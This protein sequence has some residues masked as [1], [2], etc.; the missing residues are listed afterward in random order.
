MKELVATLFAAVL[1]V[2]SAFAQTPA[3]AQKPAAASPAQAAPKAAEKKELTEQQKRMGDCSKQ[4]SDKGMKGDDRNTFMSAC[5][6]GGGDK[7][8]ACNAQADEKKLH[9][10]ARD[11]F[12]KKCASPS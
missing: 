4:A 2:P 12:V 1:A 9:G 11:S 3:P 5:L 7:M 10:A 8:A 6:K